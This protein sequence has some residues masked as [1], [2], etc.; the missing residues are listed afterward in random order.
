MYCTVLHS[1]YTVLILYY[2]ARYADKW[3]RTLKTLK[4]EKEHL[5]A[6]I[7]GGRRQKTHHF[8]ESAA[9]EAKMEEQLKMM[10]ML[11]VE[12]NLDIHHTPYCISGVY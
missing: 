11:K 3:H 6:E 9:F 8:M 4:E 5:D 12:P 1:Y 7:R 10:R 2:T